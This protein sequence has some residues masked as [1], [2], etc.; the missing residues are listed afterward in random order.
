MG[1]NLNDAVLD[2]TRFTKNRDHLLEGAV[3]EELLVQVVEMAHEA[4]L[5]SDK[6]LALDGAFLEAWASLKSFQVNEAAVRRD[7]SLF[8][9]DLC[10]VFLG[11]RYVPTYCDGIG[12][13][14]NEAQLTI[15]KS[16]CH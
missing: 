12:E 7:S 13:E 3:A 16:S 15:G 1:L 6:H 11:L 14:N 2:A 9:R 10:F 4:C 8:R 5:V